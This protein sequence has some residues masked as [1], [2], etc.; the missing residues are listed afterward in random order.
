MLQKP[1]GNLV[2]LFPSFSPTSATT[3]FLF[4]CP[5]ALFLLLL[6]LRR[7]ADLKNLSSGSDGADLKEKNT[8]VKPQV[9][10]SKQEPGKIVVRM[11]KSWC[12][13]QSGLEC[14]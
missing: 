13:G 6:K 3:P 14:Y 11:K 8:G 4:T 5:K 10:Y 7:S 12:K 9:D 2:L 1:K